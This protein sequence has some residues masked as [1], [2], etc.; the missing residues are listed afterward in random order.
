MNPAP[1]RLAAIL[2]LCFFSSTALAGKP[3][4]KVEPGMSKDQ[5]QKLLGKPANRSFRASDEA[6]QYQEVAGFGQCKYTTVWLRDSKVV[7]L[8]ERRGRSVAGC[9]LGSK[10]IDWSEM[11]Q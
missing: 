2:L 4:D 10:E 6:W 1:S 9:G 8:S 3:T 7:G 11:P 5:V